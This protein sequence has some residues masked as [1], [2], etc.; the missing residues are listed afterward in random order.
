MISV[1]RKNIYFPLI[2]AFLLLAL[3][4]CDSSRREGDD[5]HS[6]AEEKPILEA[7]LV[8]RE[9]VGIKSVLAILD[10]KSDS[11]ICIS[12]NMLDGVNQRILV[13]DGSAAVVLPQVVGEHV[14]GTTR[15]DILSE[16]YLIIPPGEEKTY[17]ISFGGY[18]SRLTGSN[19]KYSLS[20]EYL[21]CRDILVEVVGPTKEIKTY[22]LQ[23]GGVLQ[24]ENHGT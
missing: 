9:K 16:P 7:R 14:F 21:L 24:Q 1:S 3:N 20:L 11:S 13:R 4:A 8:L 12:M 18:E 6:R 22:K 15:T 5:V 19:Y 2:V 17:D 23:T 10:N